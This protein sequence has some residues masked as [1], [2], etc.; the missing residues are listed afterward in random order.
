MQKVA[1]LIPVY[2]TNPDWMEQISLGR[3]FQE[4]RDYPLI[5]VCPEDLEVDAYYGSM[6]ESYGVKLLIE[7]FESH[8][9]V[10]VSGYNRLLLSEVFYQRFIDYEYVLISQTDAY[11]FR[12]ELS[13]WCGKGYDFVGAPLF[14]QF[15][16]VEF[17]PD[18]ARVG[19]GG[20]SL[21]RVQAYLDFFQG[22]KHVFRTND[23][24]ELISFQKKPYS[25]LLVWLLMAMGWRNRPRSVARRWKYNEDDFWSGLLD[26]SNYALKKPSVQEAMLFSF[27]RFPSECFAMTGKLPFGCHAWRKYQFEEFWKEKIKG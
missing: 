12:D 20:L 21:R 26:N 17:R 4:L 10:S 22:K 23:I 14:G 15:T 11:V 8:F 9:F 6:A 3:M 25:R 1:V 16:D 19:N 7:R 2:H 24:A 27:E 13:M 5:L 18:Q